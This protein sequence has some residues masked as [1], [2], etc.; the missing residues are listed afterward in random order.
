VKSITSRD[1]SLYKSWLKLASST[2]DRRLARQTLLDGAHLLAAYLDAGGTP[3]HLIVSTEGLKNHE[4]AALIKRCPT[5]PLTQLDHSLFANL[6]ELKSLTGIISLIETPPIS[7]PNSA[8]PHFCML[9]EDVQ[10]PGNLGSILRSAAAAGCD[11]IFLSAGCT[12][13]WSPKVLRAAMGGHFSLN[14]FESTDLLTLANQFNG[15]LFA[16]S[17]NA[18]T[19]LYQTLLTGRIGLVL[20]NEGAGISPALLNQI[21]NKIL[22][23]MQNQIESL[24]VAAAGAV[25]LF[26]AARQRQTMTNLS[27]PS[28]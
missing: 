1:N 24:N 27:T 21:P 26:E 4:I 6:S 12:D 3:L 15:Q 28:P 18:S 23:P 2:R 13:V 11:S 20:G 8:I 25:C 7:N 10:D 9:L 14:L 16:L 17:L 22:I 19:N 5:Q